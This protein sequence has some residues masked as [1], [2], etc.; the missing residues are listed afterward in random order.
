VAP[1]ASYAPQHET[2]HEPAR[3]WQKWQGRIKKLDG[4]WWPLWVL[5]GA[6]AVVLL[7]TVG[8]VFGIL[9][10]IFSIVRGFIRALVG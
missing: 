3:D 5:L 9:F 7:L 8:V 4:R 6:V 1:P 10:L 2:P